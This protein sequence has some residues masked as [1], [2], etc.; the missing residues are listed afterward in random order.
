MEARHPNLTMQK[1]SYVEVSRDRAELVT[2]DAQ[3]LTERLEAVTGVRISALVGIGES[4]RPEHE[5]EH[6]SDGKAL[7]DRE[8]SSPKVSTPLSPERKIDPGLSRSKAP[9]PEPPAP[10]NH[11]EL[12]M[13]L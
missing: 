1:S 4:V 7:P 3:A 5:R 6:L 13:G 9:E 10:L 2:D 12:D 8:Q 11:V